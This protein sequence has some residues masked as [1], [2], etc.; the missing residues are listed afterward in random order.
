VFR[1]IRD[2]NIWIVYAA[3]LILGVAYGIAISLLAHHLDARGFTKPQMGSLASWFGLGIVAL[4]LPVGWAIR[5]LSAKSTLVACL[6]GYAMTVS[7]FPALDAYPA[8]AVDRFFDGAFSVGVWVSCETILLS[9]AERGIKAYVTSLYAVAIAIGYVVGPLTAEGIV[10]V[11]SIDRAFLVSGALAAFATLFVFFLLDPDGPVPALEAPKGDA[12]ATSPSAHPLRKGTLFASVKTSCFATFA[13]GYFQA[14]VVLFLPLYLLES[15][16]IA[17]ERTIIIPFFFALGML[18]FSNVAGRL[19]DRY[20]HLLV[21]RALAAV[22]MCMVL[23]FVL[24]DS[25]AWMAVAVFVAGATLAAISPVSLALLGVVTA[26]RD[27]SRSNAIYNA[28][29]ALG[30]LVGPK[31]SS[32]LFARW[33]GGAMLLHLAALWLGFVVFTAVYWKDDPRALMRNRDRGRF[34]LAPDAEPRESSS[35]PGAG[36]AARAGKLAR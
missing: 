16:G 29:Y 33:G 22:G 17:R 24:L 1:K 36:E 18:L 31:A 6:A 10:R 28:C 7:L 11:W 26:P 9:R 34:G 8:L 19:G 32:L 20:G 15:K 23:G 4:S 3:I 2:K 35:M 14:S 21:M 25:Y 13:Y 5:R 27:Y 30:M 12:S